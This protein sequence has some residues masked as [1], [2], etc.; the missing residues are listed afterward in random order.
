MSCWL[1]VSKLGT[2]YLLRHNNNTKPTTSNLEFNHNNLTLNYTHSAIATMEHQQ[3]CKT[4]SC[5]PSLVHTCGMRRPQP[6]RSHR[7]I[8]NMCQKLQ[9]LYSVCGH[10][11]TQVILCDVTADRS[12][13]PRPEPWP[14]ATDTGSKMK[15]GFLNWCLKSLRPVDN[16]TRPH[17]STCRPP[18]TLVHEIKY[19]FCSKCR[20]YYEEYATT[21][22]GK[23][24]KDPT[25]SVNVVL[26]Y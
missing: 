1:I 3:W 12:R 15:N 18:L 8:G 24:I 7:N 16:K 13:K 11:A 10:V 4:H 25:R 22:L 9:Q 26:A 5:R 6:G 21:K 20:G 17:G 14:P 19:G 23:D 2:I